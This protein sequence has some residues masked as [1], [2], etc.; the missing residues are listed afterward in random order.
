MYAFKYS[1][2]NDLI[3]LP[4]SSLETAESLEQLRWLESGYSIEMGITNYDS[5]GID[6]PEDLVKAIERL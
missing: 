1:I 6:T 5:Y 3:K 4:E 2:L